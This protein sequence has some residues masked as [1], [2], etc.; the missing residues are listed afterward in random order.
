M[1]ILLVEDDPTAAQI[2]QDTMKLWQ[3]DVVLA[4]CGEAAVQATEQQQFDLVLLD[5]ML[6]DGFGYNF[7]P[8]IRKYQPDLKIIT[9]TGNNTP[10]MEKRIR[11]YGITYYMAKPVNFKELKDII[12]HIANKSA[13]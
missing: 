10:E 6:P 3:Q 13:A 2:M 12:N 7:I 4:T 5:I 8:A 1:N 11:E 9:M